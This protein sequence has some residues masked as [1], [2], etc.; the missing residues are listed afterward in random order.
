LID[1]C[2]RN[3]FYGEREKTI[4]LFLVEIGI[5]ASELLDIDIEDIDLIE[6]SILIRQ[7][8]G[9]K[10]RTVFFG[11]TARKQLRNYLKIRNNKNGPLFTT[12]DSVRLTYTGLR[13]IVR[14]H[15]KKAGM[16]EPGL[17]DIRRTFAL[18]CLRKGIDLQ[19]IARLMGHSSLQVISRYLRQTKY[20]LGNAYR[21]L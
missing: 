3:T 19:T 14:R 11:K 7:G 4:F 10:A 21:S 20:D 15:S 5:R 9:R 6:S 12:K 17:H 13:E 2:E 16:D 18:E 1:Q 8:K